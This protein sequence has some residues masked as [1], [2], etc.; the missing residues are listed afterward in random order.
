MATLQQQI[1]EN[2]LAQLEESKK[3][4]ADKVEKLRA[5]LSCQKKPKADD[6][7]RESPES[8]ICQWRSI[9]DPLDRSLMETFLRLRP[10]HN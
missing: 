1:A 5:A 4:S 10:Q 9:V 2:F 3:I 8:R 7:P 6:F